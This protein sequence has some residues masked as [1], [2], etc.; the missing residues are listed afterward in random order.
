MRGMMPEQGR[1]RW[2]WGG[3]QTSHLPR[4][5][6]RGE[7]EM[8]FNAGSMDGPAASRELSPRPTS[9]ATRAAVA[10]PHLPRCRAPAPAHSAARRCCASAVAKQ[11]QREKVHSDP[12]LLLPAAAFGLRRPSLGS[13]GERCRA[14]ADGGS[15]SQLTAGYWQPTRLPRAARHHA[16]PSQ[17]SDRFDP[18]AC[19]CTSPVR[20]RPMRRRH[21]QAPPARCPGRSGPARS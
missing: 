6:T 13:T 14:G 8:I 9:A 21:R 16:Y 2:D 5:R 7:A 11:G 18:P 10:R 20:P 17:R 3:E 15:A 12:C 4:L 19:R 1:S